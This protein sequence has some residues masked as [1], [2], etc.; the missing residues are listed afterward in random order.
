MMFASEDQ[1]IV[2]GP[3]MIPDI[4]IVRKIDKGPD[5]GKPYWVSFTKEVIQKIAEKFMRESR[6]HETN[7]QHEEGADAKSYVMETWIVENEDDKANSLYKMGVP[8]GTWMVKMRV[9]DPMVWKQIKDGELRGFSIEGNFMSKEDYEAYQ[10]DKELYERV[11]KI[12]K[13]V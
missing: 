12:L 7:V 6:N 3:A 11:I 4:Q 10:K 1:Q 2:V 13:S 9:K 8:V 5:K